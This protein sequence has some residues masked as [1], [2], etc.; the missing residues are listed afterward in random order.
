MN[1]NKKVMAIVVTIFT[2]KK[3][4]VVKVQDFTR[5]S[6]KQVIYIGH[7]ANKKRIQQVFTAL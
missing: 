2:D 4:W 5:I 1:N 6:K 7:E 3:I